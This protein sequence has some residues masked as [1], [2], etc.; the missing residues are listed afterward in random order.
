MER[1]GETERKTEGGT[2]G[3][4]EGD[5]REIDEDGTKEEERWREGEVALEH[6]HLP[7]PRSPLSQSTSG[8]SKPGGP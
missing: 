3:E 8:I 4:R 6:S 7:I 1:G 5:E 2:G